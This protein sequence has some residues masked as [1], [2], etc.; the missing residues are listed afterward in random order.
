MYKRILIG[1]DGTDVGA[2]AVE[3]GLQIAKAFG[4][5]VVVVRPTPVWSVSALVG[6]RNAAARVERFETEA[7]EAAEAVLADVANRAKALGLEVET[8]HIKDTDPAVA[9]IDTA[10]EKDC[11]LICMGTHARR[12]LDRLMLGSAADEVMTRGGI[13]V[14]ICQ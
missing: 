13:S 2:K 5:K 11:D 10:R 8:V 6:E 12:G 3:Q 1:T 9:Y 4:S 14:L 7:L